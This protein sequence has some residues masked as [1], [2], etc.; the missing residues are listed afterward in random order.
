M[1]RSAVLPGAALR[2]LRTAAGRRA[3]HV[4]LLVGGVF[5][6]GLFCGGRAQAA[7]EAPDTLAD[8]VGRVLDV[9]AQTQTQTQTQMQRQMQKQGAEAVP[10]PRSGA[11]SERLGA[12][13]TA[14]VP[15][16]QVLPDPSGPTD[17][18]APPKPS[19]P[20][21]VPDL[22]DVPDLADLVDLAEL[23][24]FTDLTDPVGRTDQTDPSGRSG[25]AAPGP[26]PEPA[27]EA[28]EATVADDAGPANDSGAADTR[29]AEE[30]GNPA[31]VVGYGPEPGPRTVPA[32]HVRPHPPGIAHTEDAPGRPSPTGDPDGSLGAVSGADQGTSRHGD[33]RAVTPLHRITFR[34]LPGAPERADAAGVREPY[35]DIPVSPA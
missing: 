26:R 6:L 21:D 9:P 18:M 34:I 25:S 31:R 5:L 17:P 28:P 15:S 22:T 27:T 7:D 35:R 14:E 13:V 32:A 12:V 8:T 3:L 1:I 20:A 30:A 29:V 33:V 2:V 23:A 4:A 16:V 10:E 19:D 11:V 24:E